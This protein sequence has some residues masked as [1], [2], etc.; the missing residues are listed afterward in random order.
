MKTKT[1]LGI[2]LLVVAVIVGCIISYRHQ[3]A[4]KQPVL[5]PH[6]KVFVTVSGKIDPKLKITL[7]SFYN[8][9]NPDCKAVDDWFEGAYSSRSKMLLYP[10]EVKNKKYS[11]KIPVDGIESGYC[12]WK[13]VLLN[14]VAQLRKSTLKTNAPL[15]FFDLK[16]KTKTHIN[17][18][19]KKS[20]DPA[21]P[22]ECYTLYKKGYLNTIKPYHSIKAVF[23]Y[24]TKKEN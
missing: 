7:R 17:F 6:P 5:N 2:T 15:L 8:S 24:S 16:K 11:I 4:M 1:T 23:S 19:C 13:L 3:T 10:I 9:T 14:Y 20:T 22:L 12:K 21:F 18:I